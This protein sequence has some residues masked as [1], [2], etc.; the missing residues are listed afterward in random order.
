MEIYGR[1][2]SLL[3]D[4]NSIM[5]MQL[6]IRSLQKNYDDLYDHVALLS[7]RPDVICLSK[8]CINQSLKSIQLQ[9]YNSINAKPYKQARGI[10]V[11]NLNY[12]KLKLLD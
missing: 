11:L 6:N 12:P 7:F 2:L 1:T 3:N 10:D 8:F 5:L 9:S 4:S